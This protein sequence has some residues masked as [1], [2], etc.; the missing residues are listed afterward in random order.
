MHLHQTRPQKP[1]VKLCD[2]EPGEKG[3]RHVE[4]L[5]E[6]FQIN[7]LQCKIIFF[8]YLV[9]LTCLAAVCFKHVPTGLELG[10]WQPCEDLVVQRLD[11]VLWLALDDLVLLARCILHFIQSRHAG[12]E[13][14]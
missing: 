12:V 9:S 4:R 2:Q 6:L 10:L 1:Y 8:V 5:H 13:G 7:C 3:V 14:T 11:K